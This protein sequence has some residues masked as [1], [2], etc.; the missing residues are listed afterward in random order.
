MDWEP[1][2]IASRARSLGY[3]DSNVGHG[4]SV[5]CKQ[6][7]RCLSSDVSTGNEQV[8][9]YLERAA[10]RE[11]CFSALFAAVYLSQEGRELCM[12]AQVKG[13]VDFLEKLMHPATGV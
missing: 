9:Y 2:G 8:F 11:V 4:G 10:L 7:F 1:C 5:V 12:V 13:R 6:G 3:P